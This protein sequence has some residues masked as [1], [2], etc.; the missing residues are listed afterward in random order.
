MADIAMGDL[1][2]GDHVKNRGRWCPVKNVVTRPNGT[3]TIWFD[4]P[5]GGSLT[6]PTSSHIPARRR[7]E[8]SS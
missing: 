1:R 8:H 3:T 2:L 4:R 7:E 6:A 5:H